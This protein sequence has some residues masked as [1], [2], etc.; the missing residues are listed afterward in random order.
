MEGIYSSDSTLTGTESVECSRDNVGSYFKLL[1]PSKGI[2]FGQ[3]NINYLID[4]KFKQI[5]LLLTSSS[6]HADVFFITE[7]FLKPSVCDSLFEI[8]GYTILCKNRTSKAGGGVAVCWKDGLT[9]KRRFN[10]ECDSVEILS[11]ELCPYKSKRFLLIA[12]CYRPPSS[13]KADDKKFEECIE[14]AYLSGKE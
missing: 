14:K 3:W 1:L 12:G 13:T 4:S 9:F 11:L 7:T 2:R 8:L 6:S 5:K 10:L